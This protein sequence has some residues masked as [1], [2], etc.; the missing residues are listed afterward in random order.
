MAVAV[1]RFGNRIYYARKK[2]ILRRVRWSLY[3]FL[4]LVIVQAIAGGILPART[5][6]GSNLILPHGLNGVIINGNATIGNNVT[7]MHQVTVGIKDT[8]GQ[9]PTIGDD[10]FIGAGAKVLGP[11][12]IGNGAII[13]ANAVVL[14]DVPI[15]ATVV[16]IPARVVRTAS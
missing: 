12:T 10:V 7:I 13:G 8:S 2:S 6:I 15:G 4:D 11:I 9:A 3:R 1:Y 16:G 14:H 5:R